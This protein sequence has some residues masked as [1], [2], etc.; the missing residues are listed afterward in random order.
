[1]TVISLD[2][3]PLSLLTQRRGPTEADACQKWLARHLA[4]GA[5]AVVPSIVDY[6]LRRELIDPREGI[7]YFGGNKVRP[8]A[9][10]Y[11]NGSTIEVTGLDRPDKVKSHEYDS[12]EAMV[13]EFLKS[14]GA[15]VKFACFDIAGPEAGFV[16]GASLTIDGGFTA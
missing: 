5:R 1:M 13:G 12:L 7:E 16:T 2:S 6:E 8:A 15:A 14:T 10:M 4:A 11:P 9:F 3:G